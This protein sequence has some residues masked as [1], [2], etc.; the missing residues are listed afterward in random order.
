MPYVNVVGRSAI[1][2]K[3]WA[4]ACAAGWMLEE[5][6]GKRLADRLEVTVHL[7]PGL[8]RDEKIKGDCTWE[9][10]NV[11][12]RE[13]TVR[14]DSERSERE[15]F[16]ILAHELV[17]VK[18]YARMELYDT[19]KPDVVRWKRRRYK[20]SDNATVKQYKKYPWERE[21]YKLEAELYEKWI[22]KDSNK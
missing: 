6:V 13:F 20:F 16:T 7:I 8:K 15:Q 5:L 3:K 2:I 12:P 1:G 11:R 21:A 19:V 9:D 18:Q 14:I 4:Y 10:D 17:H 22:K